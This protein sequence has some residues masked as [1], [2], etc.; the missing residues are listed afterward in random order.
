MMG[1]GKKFAANAARGVLMAF[2][3]GFMLGERCHGETIP[4]SFVN[5]TWHR[6]H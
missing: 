5:N 6:H 1:N 2:G 3:I 4:F